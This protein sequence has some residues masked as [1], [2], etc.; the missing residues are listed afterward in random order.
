[1]IKRFWKAYNSSFW[2]PSVI[3][4]SLAIAYLFIGPMNSGI[5]LLV[6]IALAGVFVVSIVNLFKKRWL[7]SAINL[8]SFLILL[9]VLSVVFTFMWLFGPSGDDFAK[10]LTI[11]TDIEVVN[12]RNIKGTISA[13]T[14]DPF[15]Q[16]VLNSLNNSGS[17][18]ATISCDMS[19]LVTAY[20]NNSE[21]L[22]RYLAAHPAWRLYTRHGTL[23]ATRRWVVDGIWQTTLH[24]NYT[25]SGLKRWQSGPDKQFQTRT[26]IS[27]SADS[28]FG[29]VGVT[30]LRC[31]Q[32]Q[33]VIL[34]QERRQFAQY[35][36]YV[37]IKEN[38]LLV[39]I[40]E[41]SSAKQRRI[42]EAS[43]SYLNQEFK[44]FLTL[45]DWEQIKSML[46][47]SSI[48]MGPPSLDISGSNGIYDVY[49]RANPGERGMVYLK[50]FE[51]TKNTPLSEDDLKQDS[52]EWIGWSDN[53]QEQF[54]SNS[55]IMIYEGDWEQYYAARFEVWFAPASGGPERKLLERVF[56]I[57]GW[58]R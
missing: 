35:G 27:F 49:I 34:R 19:S 36:S 57:D 42:T 55:H 48:S 46:P 37:S 25:S 6:N 28:S 15:Q 17:D 9:K 10:N 18:N 38:N 14:D 7:K 31:G 41:Q 2:I 13:V 22:L 54:L 40:M 52:S 24:A 50:A 1:M 44:R 45:S 11:P 29:N 32:K 58:Q 5:L 39:E 8:F 20:L 21:N 3:T 53:N 47:A 23:F 16:T 4:V 33:D 43:L 26:T 30:L 56:K 12:T 51:V